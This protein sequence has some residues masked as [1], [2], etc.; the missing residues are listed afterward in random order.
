MEELNETRKE[1]GLDYVKP[2]DVFDLIS[3][4]STGGY[5]KTLLCKVFPSYRS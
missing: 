3:G 5:A 1:A 4:T 2:C